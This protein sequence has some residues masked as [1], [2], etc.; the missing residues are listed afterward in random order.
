M[1]VYRHMPPLSGGMRR[2]RGS[3]AFDWSIYPI[4]NFCEKALIL[5]PV[6][7]LFPLGRVLVSQVEGG[8]SGI[9]YDRVSIGEGT[10]AFGVF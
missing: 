3:S 1:F 2:E 7:E 5:F 6:F 4:L 9:Y 10:T 8:L